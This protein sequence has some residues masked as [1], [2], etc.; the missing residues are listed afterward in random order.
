MEDSNQRLQADL[1]AMMRG[2]TPEEHQR[3]NDQILIHTLETDQDGILQIGSAMRNGML[4]M[5]SSLSIAALIQEAEPDVVIFDC[6]ARFG[7][8]NP[9]GLGGW[10]HTLYI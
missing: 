9:G 3:V 4:D 5:S 1:T 7:A 10:S 2:L 6:F 8:G